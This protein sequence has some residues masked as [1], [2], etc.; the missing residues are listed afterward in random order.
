MQNQCSECGSNKKFISISV[1]KRWWRVCQECGSAFTEKKSSY[2]FSLLPYKALKRNNDLDSASIYDYFADAAHI[3]WSIAD[4]EELLNRY[5][6]PY[7]NNIKDKKILDISGGNG[8]ALN[9]LYKEGA[10]VELTEINEK[11]IQYAKSNF[12]FPVHYFDLNECSL[13]ATGNQSQYDIIMTRACIMFCDD[14]VRLAN[15]IYSK[16]VPG[17]FYILN[18]TIEPT[19]GIMLRT[20]FDEYSFHVLRQP[21]H[22][23]KICEDIG[24]EVVDQIDEVDPS[25][26]AYDN[27]LLNE[28]IIP[29]YLYE[30]KAMINLKEK[31]KNFYNL[32]ARDRRRSTLILKKK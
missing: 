29:H 9:Q 12:T 11:A 28:W 8:H 4:G 32:R 19:L 3:E 10:N 27:D 2:K 15:E 23:R 5:I 14:L 31:A 16:L 1:Y 13:S 25:M 26:Y 22:V 30:I 20:Q 6:T 21:A 18:N 7:I 24:F 17:G